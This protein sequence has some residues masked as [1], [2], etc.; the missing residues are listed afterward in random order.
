MRASYK[1]HQTG[2]IGSIQKDSQSFVM[3]PSHISSELFTCDAV[4][5]KDANTLQV[6]SE[7]AR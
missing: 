6:I 3:Q 5:C 4:G 1:Y 2:H 7:D